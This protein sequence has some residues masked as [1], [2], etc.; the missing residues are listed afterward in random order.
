MFVAVNV[1]GV[2]FLLR[3]WFFFL[4]CFC[5]CFVCVLPFLSCSFMHESDVKEADRPGNQQRGLPLSSNFFA[6]CDFSF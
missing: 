3:V 2:F 1:A 6:V 4:W 5:V